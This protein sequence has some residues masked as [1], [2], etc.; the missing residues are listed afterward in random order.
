MFFEVFHGES[1]GIKVVGNVFE[2]DWI[3]EM[4]VI[5][6]PIHCV[7]GKREF[8]NFREIVVIV[9]LHGTAP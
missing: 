2:Q 1:V 7:F 5:V 3:A 9:L 4:I 8:V 6:E